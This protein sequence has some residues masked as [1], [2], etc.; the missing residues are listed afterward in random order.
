[1][2]VTVSLPGHRLDRTHVLEKGTGIYNAPTEP[3]IT[4]INIMQYSNKFTSELPQQSQ[5]AA[6]RLPSDAMPENT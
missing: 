1:M 4:V 6:P 2:S 5:T 3:K